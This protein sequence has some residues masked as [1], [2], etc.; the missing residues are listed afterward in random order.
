MLCEENRNYHGL[1]IARLMEDG[2]YRMA[3]HEAEVKNPNRG[4]L[5]QTGEKR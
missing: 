3:R 1:G 2:Y 4:K 5:L